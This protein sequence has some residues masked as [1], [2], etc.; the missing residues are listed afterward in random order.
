MADLRKETIDA[1]FGRLPADVR[2][3]MP[4]GTAGEDPAGLAATEGLKGL[5]TP[6]DILT[7]VAGNQDLFLGMGRARRVRFLAWLTKRTYPEKIGVLEVLTDGGEDGG[8]G[9]MGKVAPV[10]LEDI[11]AIVEALG[12]RAARGIVDADTIAAVAGAGYEL[13]SEMDMRQGGAI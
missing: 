7:Y 10:F 4:D 8:Q 3:A 11:R 13:A 1:W 2:S 12:P 5:S 6:E 9:V